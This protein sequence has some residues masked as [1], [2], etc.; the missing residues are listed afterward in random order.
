M[1]AYEMMANGYKKRLEHGE[2]DVES[3]NRKIKAYDFLATCDESD[4]ETLIDS[5]AF[6]KFIKAY[7][8]KA[9]ETANMG[10]EVQEQVL[11]QLE[12][13]FETEKANDIA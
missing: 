4:L 10:K 1:N 9:L 3:A 11:S 7:C 6:N 13:L 8:R 2:I 5:T 12:R